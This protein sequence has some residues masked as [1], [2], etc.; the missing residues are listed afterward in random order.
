MRE[1]ARY[2]FDD[3]PSGGYSSYTFTGTRPGGAIAAA[4]AGMHFLGREGYRRIAVAS[5]RAKSAIALGVCEI[6]GVMVYGEPELWAF[7]FGAP[8]LA[9]NRV[10]ALMGERGW[11]CGVTTEPPGIH[12]MCSPVHEP[13]AGEYVEAMRE[14]IEQVRAEAKP[15]VAAA[16]YS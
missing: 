6:P 5:M 10:A 12:V 11:I 16:P 3:W 14:C 13:A 2:R 15:D 4:W 9:M 8:D 1:F 7:A